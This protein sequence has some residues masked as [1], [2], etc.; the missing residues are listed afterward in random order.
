[1][2]NRQTALSRQLAAWLALGAMAGV[3]AMAAES[4][5]RVNGF[6]S[7]VGSQMNYPGSYGATQKIRDTLSFQPGSVLGMQFSYQMDPKTSFNTQLISRAVEDWRVNS[8]RAFFKYQVNNNLSFRA[9]RQRTPYFFFSEAQEVG[10]AY[11]WVLPPIERYTNEQSAY[12]GLAIRQSWSGAWAGNAEFLLGSSIR[13][14]G[15]GSQE[16]D[17]RTKRM[18]G[19]VAN[20]YKGQWTFRAS[21]IK[22]TFLPELDSSSTDPQVVTLVAVNSALDRTSNGAFT[23]GAKV[24]TTDLAAH[25]DSRRWF[26]LAEVGAVDYDSGVFADDTV[27]MLTLGMHIQ[28]WSPYVLVTKARTSSEGDSRREDL[29]AELQSATPAPTAAVVGYIESQTREQTSYSLGVRYDLENNID[30][31][32]QLTR[33]TDLNETDGYFNGTPK[34]EGAT[35]ALLSLDAMF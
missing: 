34:H 18:A 22:G 25:Y 31:K 9:G 19:L 24:V 3:P 32:F 4:P 20:L 5:L 10:F 1:M 8:E 30:V 26:M 7:A 12:D 27:G 23:D 11:P 35:I 2:N 17:S 33:V 28:K 16:Y 21:A 13:G 6:L 14:R 29:I 15:Q